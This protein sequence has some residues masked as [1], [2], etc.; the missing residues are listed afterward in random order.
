MVGLFAVGKFD[1]E[2]PQRRPAAEQALFIERDL[3]G[4]VAVV[5]VGGFMGEDPSE[6]LPPGLVQAGQEVLADVAEGR[7]HGEFEVHEGVIDVEQNPLDSAAAQ[8]RCQHVSRGKRAG[9]PGR[10]PCPG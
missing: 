9:G 4:Q 6:P 10:N 3:A 2:V 1:A 5:E 8:A 7:R